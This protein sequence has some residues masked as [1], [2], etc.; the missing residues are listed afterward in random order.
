[1]YVHH[2]TMFLFHLMDFV[3]VMTWF[4]QLLVASYEALVAD[5]DVVIN[6][7]K[8]QKVL[9][10]DVFHQFPHTEPIL[11]KTNTK[12]SLCLSTQQ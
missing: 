10:S 7:T 1:M 3:K 5:A 11:Q 2:K 9:L 6:T 4:G 8:R 12:L